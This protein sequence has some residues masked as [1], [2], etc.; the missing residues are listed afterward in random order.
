VNRGSLAGPGDD[1]QIAADHVRSL[2]HADET[3]TAAVSTDSLQ[4][5]PPTVVSD[6]QLDVVPGSGDRDRQ[7]SRLAVY[8]V[9]ERLL[10]DSKQ[11]QRDIRVNVP[12]VT[13][14]LEAHSNLMPFLDLDAVRFQCRSEADQSQGGRVQ[15]V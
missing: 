14:N 7:S 5:E 8:G 4:V 6:G 10:S 3:E 15:I 12:E 11:G 1:L 9:S 13:L 2:L